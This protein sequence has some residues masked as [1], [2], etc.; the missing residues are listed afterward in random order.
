VQRRRQSFKKIVRL[1]VELFDRHN[2][3][4]YA[5]AIALRAFIAAV[6]CTLFGLG[7]LGATHQQRL[8]RQTIGPAIEPKLLPHVF[9]GID[10]TV[11]RVFSYVAAIVLLVAM[12]LDEL[13]RADLQRPRAKQKLLPLVAGVIRG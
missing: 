13:V 1:W 12:Q 2:L 10:Q 6:A 11:N 3:L 4:T 5:S 7:I 8:W 9:D